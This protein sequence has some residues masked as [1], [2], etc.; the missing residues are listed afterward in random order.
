MSPF[1]PTQS[2]KVYSIYFL[3]VK[4]DW[5]RT[6]LK[7]NWKII[8]VDRIEIDRGRAEKNFSNLLF[9]LTNLDAALR[10]PAGGIYEEDTHFLHASTIY[11]HMDGGNIV[12]GNLTYIKHCPTPYWVTSPHIPDNSYVR[13]YIRMSHGDGLLSFLDPFPYNRGL[14]IHGDRAFI[15][16]A[17]NEILTAFLKPENHPLNQYMGPRLYVRMPNH[18]HTLYS[19]TFR[20]IDGYRPD[21]L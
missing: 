19:A 2:S 12:W 15:R 17:N 16:V 9:F 1:Y 10:V 7:I 8:D 21:W 20:Y 13:A 11:I 3:H 14:N 6:I 4:R 5:I 18:N